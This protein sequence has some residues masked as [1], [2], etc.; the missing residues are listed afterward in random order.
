M[1]YSS[2]EEFKNLYFVLNSH[3]SFLR[4]INT[5]YLIKSLMLEQD[6]FEHA[7]RL[8]AFIREVEK[9]NADMDYEERNVLIEKAKE[10]IKPFLHSG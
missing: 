10:Y 9:L 8:G 1:S 6:E 4:L 7:L 2:T 5:L 3:P